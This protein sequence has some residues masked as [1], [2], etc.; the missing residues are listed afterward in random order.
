MKNLLCS[1]ALIC[2]FCVYAAVHKM[3]K[4]V[5]PR[6]GE[7]Y[8]LT[9]YKCDLITDSFSVDV[10]SWRESKSAQVEFYA[11]SGARWQRLIYFMRRGNVLAPPESI[12]T[13]K[14]ENGDVVATACLPVLKKGGKVGTVMIQAGQSAQY[15]DWTF[16]R[17][18]N[19]ESTI[20]IMTIQFGV[21]LIPQPQVKIPR[22]LFL[23]WPG[24]RVAIGGD[25]DWFKTVP[26]FNALAWYSRGGK[27]DLWCDYMV[28]D[29]TTLKPINSA[30][31]RKGDDRASLSFAPAGDEMIVALGYNS[32]KD[33]IGESEEAPRFFK[34]KAEKVFEALKSFKWDVQTD[35]DALKKQLG[36]LES[37]LKQAPNQ[38]MQKQYEE[39][40]MALDNAIQ[41]NDSTAAPT[42]SDN[43]AKLKKEASKA[44][45]DD[46]F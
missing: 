32:K 38:H 11:V 23:A 2:T 35:W 7:S 21:A 25:V 24:H 30:R 41:A 28:F 37:I 12:F 44:A 5:T 26:A 39:L 18:K 10:K 3:E 17:L 8:H 4:T 43:I 15:P 31:W 16:L 27:E 29:P 40:K 36:E 46:L 33:S 20:G 9:R 14:N 19:S 45:L 34:D 6:G 22:T 42:L 1:I 13:S